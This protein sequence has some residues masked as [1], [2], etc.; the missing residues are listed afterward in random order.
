MSTYL[1]AALETLYDILR[2]AHGAVAIPGK[3]TSVR[4]R[5]RP[6]GRAEK[7]LRSPHVCRLALR[8]LRRGRAHG[9]SGRMVN[10]E[11]ERACEFWAR[12]AA[13]WGC[14]RAA[15]LLW[16]RKLEID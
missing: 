10:G 14:W 2:N 9:V 7:G 1:A 4:M 16:A 8:R 5:M 15:V 3:P 11:E 13:A 12:Q 6:E